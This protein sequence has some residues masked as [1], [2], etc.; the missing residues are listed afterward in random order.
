M[1]KRKALTRMRNAEVEVEFD[2]DGNR[3]GDGEAKKTGGKYKQ[4]MP[5]QVLEVK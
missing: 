1:K 5:G 3:K 2:E 4:S